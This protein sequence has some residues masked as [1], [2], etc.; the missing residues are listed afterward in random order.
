MASADEGAADGMGAAAVDKEREDG[1]GVEGG[2]LVEGRLVGEQGG[3]I[4]FDQVGVVTGFEAADDVLFCQ[5]F[6]GA[7]GGEVEGVGGGEFGDIGVLEAPCFL[8]FE[9]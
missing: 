8:G 2:E 1:P 9:R 7:G 5:R 3:E 4:E 6:G